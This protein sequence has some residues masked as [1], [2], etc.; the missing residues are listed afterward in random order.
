MSENRGVS[1]PRPDDGISR[2]AWCGDV[3]LDLGAAP[4]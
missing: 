4:S 2:D 3:L 1:I